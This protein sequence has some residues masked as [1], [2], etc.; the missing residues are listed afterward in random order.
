MS[1]YDNI[2]I[3][4]NKFN[5][6]LGK[7]KHETFS[8]LKIRNYRLYFIGQGTSLCGTL[9]QNVALSWLVL[10]MTGSGT[11]LG[12]V[13]ALQ[14]LPVLVFAPIGGVL[15][16]RFNKRKL[17]YLTQS[18][19]GILALI[20]GLLVAANKIELWMVYTIAFLLG[21][22]KAI[23]SPTQTTFTH[24]MVGKGQIKNAVILNSI[25]FNTARFVGPAMGGIIIAAFGLSACFLVNAASFIA[26]LICLILMD[27][28]Q[29][30]TSEP[31]KIVKGQFSAGLKYAWHTAAIRDILIMMLIVGTL[32]YEFQVSLPLLAKFTFHGEVNT[33]ALFLS[34]I[35]IGSVVG[36][37]FLAGKKDLGVRRV[38]FAA[39]FFGLI[40]FAGSFAPNV[41][42]A[43]FAMF[44]VGLFSIGF[45]T[46]G[47]A[48]IQLSSD[49]SMRGRV[50]AL[51]TTALTGSTFIGGPIIGYI[52]QH[53]DPR[54]GLGIGGISAL[55]AGGYGLIASRKYCAK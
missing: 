5:Y 54:W 25:L 14:F 42:F 51:W 21:T 17:L 18:L 34:A 53:I 48:T 37:F 55:V 47:N 28:K 16:D 30:T 33:L 32:A 26:V 40:M 24:E 39:L 49:P 38:A 12:L 36:G 44:L 23:D 35:G 13:T 29:L 4:T 46:Q 10:D 50:M 8:S 45:T 19:T 43:A 41:Y 22:V 15:V 3:M 20:L 9:M 6:L 52:G 7:L 1:L 2:I 11:A 31:I 27:G